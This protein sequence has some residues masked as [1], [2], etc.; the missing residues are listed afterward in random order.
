MI[1]IDNL[2]KT[3]G[4]VVALDQLS[5]SV[6]S[7]K[8]TTLL[9][10]NGSGKTTALR[11]MTGLLPFETGHIEVGG[12]DVKQQP[13]QARRLMGVF[14]DQFGLYPRLTT[15]EHLQYFGRLHGLHKIKLQ[16]AINYLVDA[17]QLQD[18]IDRRTQGFSQGQRMKVALGRALV[19]KPRL[20]I[21][22]E[23][24]RGLDILSI[25]LL[26]ELLLGLKQNGT[27][28]L[29]SSHVMAEVETLS[30]DIIII[31]KGEVMNTGSPLEL[32][33]ATNTDSLEKA[34]IALINNNEGTGE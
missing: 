7:E 20:L 26:R 21:L 29:L 11:A 31:N 17:L 13:Q 3:Y 33:Q 5:L 6:K 23:P 12:I 16:D 9:G 34:F 22:D 2:T 4:S 24:T 19:H 32:L 1:T 27:T 14:P 18:I 30:D 15:R 28:I 8:I 10:A 25:R